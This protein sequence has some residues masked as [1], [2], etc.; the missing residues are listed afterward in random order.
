MAGTCSPYSIDVGDRQADGYRDITLKN[1]GRPTLAAT[2]REVQWTFLASFYAPGENPGM[3]NVNGDAPHHHPVAADAPTPPVRQALHEPHEYLCI[4]HREELPDKNGRYV[5]AQPTTLC[6]AYPVSSGA[7]TIFLL[8]G[9]TPTSMVP[10]RTGVFIHGQRQ[11]ARWP[12][13]VSGTLELDGELYVAAADAWWMA[14]PLTVKPVYVKVGSDGHPLNPSIAPPGASS[15]V[16]APRI[17]SV[18]SR[19]PGQQQP[20]GM[21]TLL[22]AQIIHQFTAGA[23][24]GDGGAATFAVVRTGPEE[25][26]LA[27]TCAVYHLDSTVLALLPH[28][29]AIPGLCAQASALTVTVSEH[30]LLSDAQV[31]FLYDSSQCE[32]YVIRVTGLCGRSSG[33]GRGGGTECGN[34]NEE[35]G[36]DGLRAPGMELLFT[37]RNANLPVVLPSL[38]SSSPQPVLV[39]NYPDANSVTLFSP[40]RALHT[41]R[42]GGVCDPSL[43]TLAQ[44]QLPEPEQHSAATHSTRSTLSVA[45]DDPRFS[46][47][48][49]TDPSRIVAVEFQDRN[50]VCF[51]YPA[52]AAA[53]VSSHHSVAAMLPQHRLLARTV[54]FPCLRAEGDTI[55]NSLLEV[56]EAAIGQE[57]VCRFEEELVRQA[58]L[59]CGPASAAAQTSTGSATL[60]CR[61]LAEMV[62]RSCSEHCAEKWSGPHSAAPAASL[63]SY[64]RVLSAVIDPLAITVDAIAALC[65]GLGPAAAPPSSDTGDSPPRWPLEQCGLC[66]VAVHLLCEAC[67]LQERLWPALDVLTALAHRLSSALRWSGYAAVYGTVGRTE[68]S[69]VFSAIITP[70]VIRNRFTFMSDEGVGSADAGPA[71]MRG[72]PHARREGAPPPFV[73]LKDDPIGSTP[74]AHGAPPNLHEALAGALQGPGAASQRLD[75]WPILNGLLD[76]HPL[77]VAN[78]VFCVYLD[79]VRGSTTAGAPRGNSLPW[80]LRVC[81]ALAGKGVT[82]VASRGGE[83]SV[84]AALPVLRALA[85]GRDAVNADWDDSLAAVVGR[86]DWVSDPR[87]LTLLSDPSKDVVRLAEERAVGRQYQVS[88]TDDDGVMARLDFA[89][90]WR[91]ARLDMAQVYFN[92]SRSIHIPGSSGEQ[93]ADALKALALRVC[94]MP[95]GRGMLTM[96]T[97]NFKVRDSIPIPRLNLDGRTSDGVFVGNKADDMQPAA[98]IWP[99]FHNGCAAGLRFLPLDGSVGASSS[100]GGGGGSGADAV[101]QSQENVIARHWVVYLTKNVHSPAARAGLLLA[102]GILGHLKVLQLTDIYSLLVSPPVHYHGHEA[103]TMAVMLGLGCS[104]RGTGNNLVFR[105]LSIHVHSLTPSAEDIDVLLDVQTCAL[106]SIGVLYQRAP[107]NSFLADMFL[108]EMSRLPSDEHCVNREGYALGAGVGLGLMLLGLGGAH[109]MSR[110]E[111]RLFGFLEGR[112]RDGAL[113]LRDGGIETYSERTSDVA[114]NFLT[115]ALLMQTQQTAARTAST[116]VHEGEYYN[117][118]VSGPAACVAL[119]LMYLQT[120][121][122]A[123]ADQLRPPDRVAALQSVSPELCLLRTLFASMVRWSVIVPTDAHIHKGC[124]PSVLQGLTAQSGADLDLAGQQVHYLMMNHGHCI[125]GA[126]LA[127]GFRYAGSMDAAARELILAELRGFLKGHLGATGIAVPPLQRSTGAYE[128]CIL[129]CS[130][131]VG[132][133]MAGTGDLRT[134]GMFQRMHGRPKTPFGSHMTLSMA[135]GL[136]F[137]GSGRLTLS[138]SLDSV[139]ALVVALYPVWPQSP[140]D[141]VNHL[142]ILRHLYGLAVVPRV[143]ETVNAVS[144]R[145]VSVPVRVVLRKGKAW[146]EAADLMADDGGGDATGPRSIIGAPGGATSAPA[147]GRKRRSSLLY[148]ADGG[149]GSAKNPSWTPMPRGREQQEMRLVTPCLYPPPDMIERIE[150]RSSRHYHRVLQRDECPIGERGLVVRLLESGSAAAEEEERNAVGGGAT[151][152]HSDAASAAVAATLLEQRLVN[153]VRRLFSQRSASRAESAAI[154]D[155]I[156]LLCAGNRWTN[157]QDAAAAPSSDKDGAAGEGAASPSALFASDSRSGGISSDVC[158]AVERSLERRYRSLFI[159]GHGPGSSRAGH[160]LYLMISQGESLSDV[161]T[162]IMECPA[163][164]ASFPLDFTAMQSDSTVAAS[165]G[166]GGSVGAVS[167]D[168]AEVLRWLG[169]AVHFYFGSVSAF[170]T[171]ARRFR[172]LAPQ[173]GDKSRRTLALLKLSRECGLPLTL[174]QRVVACCFED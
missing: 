106:V 113:I 129:A 87:L 159:H 114:G 22:G 30:P 164:T 123:V 17:G 64:T 101:R 89:Q 165:A 33:G 4:F 16:P 40:M 86:I 7:E 51:L 91:D 111:E 42:S 3:L 52:T 81:L 25:I 174:L 44:A 140:E 137:L 168:R 75:A 10:G 70:G 107:I 60:A 35:I 148:A 43:C 100:A 50:T 119:G 8:Q 155:S 152:A 71:W 108:V 47:T 94:A 146:Q 79:A 45:L 167:L 68:L 169:E 24:P 132:L 56:L 66:T 31:L 78:R 61:V 170:D 88:L 128:A 49:P 14:S 144:N 73:T 15:P 115:R 154:L 55:L 65:D 134:F 19:P 27:W 18:F 160:P 102:A 90:V 117:T 136:L 13:G 153:W 156:R 32:I 21:A 147:T 150:I 76:A 85:K 122:T 142:Q 130:I 46:G 120:D 97:H 77:A 127:L 57:P 37:L 171:V 29:L 162:A 41:L 99:L 118:A 131:A 26:A 34:E 54:E 143:L 109:G 157:R 6:S 84:G 80:W 110:V 112:R 158:R 28:R 104:F 67:K 59:T 124:V 138:T 151:G 103:T 135:S 116:R 166:G 39:T 95:M 149:E 173:L 83:L 38:R 93:P 12:P 92:T 121:N 48:L 163:G 36:A 58:W 98:L 141:N 105:C 125:A 82:D 69:S 133:V 11:A 139:A 172:E 126:V 72:E 145:P 161:A 20:R 62:E 2:H 74:F 5:V 1:R 53:A 23:Q 96:G 63:S 9:I